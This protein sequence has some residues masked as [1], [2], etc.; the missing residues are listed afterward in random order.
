MWKGNVFS[1]VYLSVYSQGS[2]DRSHR[3]LLHLF[4]YH[5][6]AHPNHVQIC[7]IAPLSR[8]FQICYFLDPLPTYWQASSWPSTDR[9]SYR[10]YL[11]KGKT[12]KLSS[13]TTPEMVPV[14]LPVL[15]A[16]S[17]RTPQLLPLDPNRT[18]QPCCW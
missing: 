7:S 13:P 17:P 18:T 12:V 6:G 11:Q 4:I 16:P 3:T 2:T 14:L 9:L 5:M 10:L 1:C 15:V 8:S